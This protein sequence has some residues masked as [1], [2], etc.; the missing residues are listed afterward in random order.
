MPHFRLRPRNSDDVQG[1]YVPVD[2]LHIPGDRPEQGGRLPALRPL[3]GLPH[4]RGRPLQ[5][6]GQ[7]D[8]PRTRPQQPGHLLDGELS[9]LYS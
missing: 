7:R 4:P 8:G 9:T 5:E 2:E 3:Q 1:V 6:P